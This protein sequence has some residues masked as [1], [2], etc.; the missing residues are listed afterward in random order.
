MKKVLMIL[1]QK[2]K[3]SFIVEVLSQYTRLILSR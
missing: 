2:I 1:T 3:L